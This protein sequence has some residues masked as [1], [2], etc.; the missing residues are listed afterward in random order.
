MPGPWFLEIPATEK[1]KL[2]PLNRRISKG[3]HAGKIHLPLAAALE[4]KMITARPQKNILTAK[5]YFRKHLACGDLLVEASRGQWIGK[6]V[7]RLGIDPTQPVTAQTFEYLCDNLHPAT[8]HRLTVRQ[9]AENRRIFFDF[10]ISPPKSVSV[11]AVTM[12]DQRIVGL[13][14]R[15]ARIAAEGM[16][17]FAAT[18]VRRNGLDDER[19]TAE[20]IAAAFRH[21]C[22][23][24]F[25][26]QLHTH[27]VVFNATWDPVEK[28]WKALEP[29]RIFEA[30]NYFTEAYR[31]E[32]AAGLKEFGYRLRRTRNGFEIE[33]VSADIIRRFSKRRSQMEAEEARLN[34]SHPL[35]FRGLANLAQK[36]RAA[37]AD[38]LT[39]EDLIRHQREQLCGDELTALSRVIREARGVR[40]EPV[41][42]SATQALD[43]ARDHL[44]E[45]AS[46][47]KEYDL[48]REALIF[49]RGDVRVHQ[50][51]SCLQERKEFLKVEDCLT[52]REMLRLERELIAW[53]NAQSGR[54]RPFSSVIPENNTLNEAQRSAV[55]HLLNST[56]GVTRI[57]GGA[58]TGK[59]YVLKTFVAALEDRGH[60]VF[61][62]APTTG[63]VDVLRR[64]GFHSAQTVQRLLTDETLQGEIRGQTILVDEANLLS[65]RQF[66][67][68]FLTAKAQR[69]RVVLS[70]DTRQHHSV[71]AGDAL[72]ILEAHSQLR[73]VTLDHI[74]RQKPADYRAAVAEI[75]AGR[76]FEA[77]QRLD[78]I[79]V[80]VEA[81]GD[82][83]Q[84]L[85]R[86][87]SDSLKRGRSALIVAPTWR[88]I[89]EVT[90]CV[91]SQLKTDGKLDSAEHTLEVHESL[92]WTEAQRRDSRNYRP[93]LIV[94]FH[95]RTECFAPGEWAR[96]SEINGEKIN[97]RRADGTQEVITR[98]QAKCFDVAQTKKLAV[99][100]GEKLLLQGN[101]RRKRLINGQ[102]VTVKNVDERSRIHLDDGRT[103][104][105]GF[106]S[107]TYGYCV[108]S[109]AAEGKTVDHVYLAASSRSFLAAHREQFY[110]SVSRG[111]Y[112]AR[113]FT[114]DKKGLLAA[115]RASGARLSGVE[116]FQ[117]LRRPKHHITATKGQTKGQN[118]AASK[119]AI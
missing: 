104:E 32:L 47:V 103:I 85:A 117:G 39:T 86:E 107:F 74:Q 101:S 38:G 84:Q 24:A 71:E 36:T 93:G 77:Y 108:T 114:D 31:S 16:E 106:R 28:R 73:S 75:A 2:P 78:R 58:G 110:V 83:H 116:L 68:L 10:V 80:I 65:V 92:D 66:H 96:V 81:Q 5:L 57:G 62:C 109:H 34:L 11:L 59:T 49:G 23:R 44:F 72:R 29:G 43:H 30:L 13:H 82:G 64:D 113:I 19:I 4:S 118:H 42:L 41:Q 76:T 112:R 40:T 115:V 51:A 53:V 56:D 9:R 48:L 69:C 87:F 63:A 52:T 3:A 99:A 89:G 60:S 25:D 67:S 22:S 26:P 18:R 8:G 97:V 21:E 111:R 91:R 88:E 94:R 55:T 20:I 95:K 12:G 15:A 45:R 27:L 7:T 33:G 17:K 6:G 46:T 35:R 37:T 50:L 119:I 105:P 14:D 54:Y 100:A 102:L 70:G 79:G 61:V 1:S 90:D 98:K